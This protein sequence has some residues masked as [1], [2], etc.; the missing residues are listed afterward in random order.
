VIPEHALVIRDLEL[1]I[2]NGGT[3]DLTPLSIENRSRE[4]DL[5]LEETGLIG[6]GRIIIRTD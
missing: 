3:N 5:K 4:V 6:V 2:G 1:Y